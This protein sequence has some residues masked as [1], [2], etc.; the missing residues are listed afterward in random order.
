MRKA[1]T[2]SIAALTLA[3]AAPAWA[4]EDPYELKVDVI[5]HEST[6]ETHASFKLPLTLCQ[7]WLYLTDHDDATSIPGIV[8]SKTTRLAPDKVRVERTMRDTL[9]F[10]PIRMHTVMDYTELAD[11]GTDFVQVEGEARTHRGSWRIESVEGGGTVFR[12]HAVSEPD[13]ALPLPVIRFFLDK[14]LRGSFLTM[15]QVG[16]KRKDT[17]CGERAK[18]G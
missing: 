8:S 15:A 14:R 10:F 18:V 7:A 2:A 4:Q 17:G 11:K 12:Y 6:F 5:Q 16:A 3:A 1:L 9:L 13:S